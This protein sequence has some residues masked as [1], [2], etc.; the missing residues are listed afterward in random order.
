M[1]T[2]TTGAD[3]LRHAA[4][5]LLAHLDNVPRDVTRHLLNMARELDSEHATAVMVSMGGRWVRRTRGNAGPG[6]PGV[7]HVAATDSGTDLS[8]AVAACGSR[9]RGGLDWAHPAKPGNH[10]VGWQPCRVCVG[11]LRVRPA[12]QPAALDPVTWG[13][14]PSSSTARSAAA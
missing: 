13:A 12:E 4:R 6:V 2:A 8:N 7:G 14:A 9:L 11:S 5:D 3:L 1:T 10:A